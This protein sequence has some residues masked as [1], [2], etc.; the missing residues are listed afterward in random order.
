MKIKNKV[1]IIIVNMVSN[2]EVDEFM[3]KNLI[4]EKKMKYLKDVF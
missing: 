3:F 1:F 2:I 4:K